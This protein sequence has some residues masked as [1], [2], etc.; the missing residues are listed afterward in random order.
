MA[1]ELSGKTALVTGSTSGIGR[2]TADALVAMG[3]HVIVSGRDV[4]R[5]NKAV[6]EIR[7]LGGT[8]DF[9]AADLSDSASVRELAETAR[10]LGGGHIDI[11]VNNAGIYPFGPTADFDES[12][13][14]A[15]YDVNVKAPFILAGLLAPQMADRG[16][17]AIV[18][19]STALAT[20]GMAG[21]ALYGSSKA[22]V[23]LLTKAWAAEFG[24]SGVRVNAV[25][26]GA[27]ATEGTAP[28]GSSL[29]DMITGAPAGRLGQP[30]EIA[31]GVAFLVSDAARYIHGV[32][33]PVDGGDGAV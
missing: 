25:S 11:L 6:A 19:I 30:D 8:A 23:E 28:M 22:A 21:G 33:L 29:D 24:P 26:P 27:I 12:S 4:S 2:A 14:N 32:V 16:H 20:R 1:S 3:A 10:T 5:G 31:S 17:G 13:F 9:A 18:N 7:A 15:V